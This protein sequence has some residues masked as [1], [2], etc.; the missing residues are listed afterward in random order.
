[1]S[2]SSRTG[3]LIFDPDVEKT[4]CQTRKETRQLRE[5]QSSTASQGLN[6][7]VESTDSN[8][9]NSNDPGEEDIPMANARTLREL[10]VSEL[11]Q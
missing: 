7:E 9:E 2:R 4:T 5:E 6:L 3:E 1:M 8:G 11:P 10:T